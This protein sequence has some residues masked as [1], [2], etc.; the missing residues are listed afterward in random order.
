M[1]Q[2]F[3][4]SPCTF[5]EDRAMTNLILKSAYDTVYQRSAIVHTVVPMTYSKLCKMFIRWNRSYVREELRFLTIVWKRPVKT[6]VIALCDRIITN[7]RY[8]VHYM[9]LSLLALLVMHHPWML[10]RILVAIGLI[11]L[12]NMT[13]YLCSERSPDF[14]YGVLY[15]YF[16]F[17]ALSWIFPYAAF[18]V[19]ARSW[20]TR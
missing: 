18:T 7:L 3:L 13:Y 19:R 4:G 6:R 11:S 15:S 17:V 2:T 9:S 10:A 14:C 5:G 20:L 1:E 12:F 16:A 8:P